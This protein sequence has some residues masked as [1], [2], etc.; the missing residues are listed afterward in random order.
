MTERRRGP[1]RPVGEEVADLALAAGDHPQ[2]LLEAGDVAEPQVAL[3]GTPLDRV[4]VEA[5]HAAGRD[6]VQP[7]VVAQVVERGDLG[8][9]VEV[10]VRPQE[11]DRLVVDLRFTALVVED[12]DP[13]PH[14]AVG[15]A[16]RGDPRRVHALAVDPPGVRMMGA[17]EVVDREGRHLVAPGQ[18]AGCPLDRPGD[19]LVDVVDLPHVVPTRAP[20]WPPETPAG[21]ASS[22]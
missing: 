22:P 6:R 4:G 19:V 2:D 16:I 13:A 12:G 8:E 11:A 17:P 3:D 15:A 7:V 10:E 5:Q 18:D 21:W 14:G 1:Q 20:S 9:V